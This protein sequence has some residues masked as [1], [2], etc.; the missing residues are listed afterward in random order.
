MLQ[1]KCLWRKKTSPFSIVDG[2]RNTYHYS[3]KYQICKVDDQHHIYHHRNQ[4]DM[5]NK[6]HVQ[7]RLYCDKCRCSHILYP[8]HMDQ[9]MC[10]NYDQYLLYSRYLMEQRMVVV[11]SL[12]MG[13]KMNWVK[14]EMIQQLRRPFHPQ[15]FAVMDLFALKIKINNII[16]ILI[17]FAIEIKLSLSVRERF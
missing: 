7:W 4:L 9:Y 11:V 15:T 14:K 8:C 2:I 16:T 1:N 12:P 17:K 10:S 3:N 6:S 5:N 13:Q